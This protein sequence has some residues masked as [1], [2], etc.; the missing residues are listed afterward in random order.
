MQ[1]EEKVINKKFLYGLLGVFASLALIIYLIIINTGGA[2]VSGD[3]LEG[4]YYFYNEYHNI[5]VSN[6]FLEIDEKVIKHRDGDNN[7]EFYSI[8]TEKQIITIPDEN[9]YPYIYENGV[10]IF[11]YYEDEYVKEGS[12]KFKK[13]KKMTKT[14]YDNYG[15]EE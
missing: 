7:E 12:K 2:I 14:E 1:T 15:K 3:N 5:V 10:L 8:D 13:A 4:K 6:N 11:G 9:E